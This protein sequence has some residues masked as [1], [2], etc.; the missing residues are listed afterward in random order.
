MWLI[1]VPPDST[2]FVVTGLFWSSCG[3]TSRIFPRRGG[4]ASA[5]ICR[6]RLDSRGTTARA[7]FGG[8][9]GRRSE[10][11]RGG[12]GGATARIY[13]R[14]LDSRGAK[15]RV[16]LEGL[17]ER[18]PEVYRGGGGGATDRNYRRGLDSRGAKARDRKSTR[19]NSSPDSEP[20]MPASA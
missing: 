17:E 20:R 5:I 13:R 8:L 16:L 10:I 4:G 12:G 11:F 9:G 14:G 7:F 1:G 6:R 15:A 19:L 2:L 18:R 3:A